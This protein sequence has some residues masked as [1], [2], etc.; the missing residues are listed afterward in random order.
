MTFLMTLTYGPFLFI[1]LC[2]QIMTELR[3]LNSNK[4]EKYGN[5]IF[6]VKSQLVTSIIFSTLF[7]AAISAVLIAGVV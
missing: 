5:N 3:D 1:M 4:E 6:S 2:A 7:V